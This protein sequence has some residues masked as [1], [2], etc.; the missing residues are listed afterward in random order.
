[1][2][3]RCKGEQKSISKSGEVLFVSYLEVEKVILQLTESHGL[4]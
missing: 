4:E 1:M 3:Q 2:C